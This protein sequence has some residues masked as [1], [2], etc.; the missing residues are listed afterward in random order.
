MLILSKARSGPHANR[1]A[2]P[3]HTPTTPAAEEEEEEEQPFF[4][5]LFHRHTLGE[6]AWLVHVAAAFDGDVVGQQLQRDYRQERK[7]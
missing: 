2:R 3:P 1:A 6:V 4:S 5:R 7:E